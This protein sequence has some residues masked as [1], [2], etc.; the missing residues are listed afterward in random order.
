MVINI[1]KNK[2]NYYLSNK[3]DVLAIYCTFFIFRLGK[4]NTEYKNNN[5]VLFKVSLEFE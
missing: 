1:I 3:L 5:S 4:K 2:I